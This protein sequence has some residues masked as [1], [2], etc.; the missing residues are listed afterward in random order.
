MLW[1]NYGDE[2]EGAAELWHQQKLSDT[3]R[4]SDFSLMNF[5]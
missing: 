4:T 2:H 5:K 3:V 1:C